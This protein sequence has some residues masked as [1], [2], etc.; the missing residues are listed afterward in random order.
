MV[1][2]GRVARSEPDQYSGPWQQDDHRSE[3]TERPLARV[4]GTV[5]REKGK[6]HM[7]MNGIRDTGDALLAHAKLMRNPLVAAAFHE[8]DN[9][10]YK[11]CVRNG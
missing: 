1:V 3:T 9:R 5:T 6:D 8:I 10:Y 11:L 2:R 7:R 4:N